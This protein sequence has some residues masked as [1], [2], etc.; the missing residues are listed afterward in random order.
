MKVCMWE[1]S[2]DSSETIA[3]ST[4][5]FPSPSIE[6][7]TRHALLKGDGLALQKL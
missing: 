1:F 3:S 2:F 7:M 5:T 4:A 6:S